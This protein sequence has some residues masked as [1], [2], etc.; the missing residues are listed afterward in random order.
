MITK[1]IIYSEMNPSVKET[2][3]ID[4]EM[5][6]KKYLLSTTELFTKQE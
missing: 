1:N 4:D 3:N 6:K 2:K 5:L